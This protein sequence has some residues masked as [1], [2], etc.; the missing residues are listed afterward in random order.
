MA[1]QGVSFDSRGTARDVARRA[2]EREKR[3]V[4]LTSVAAA[5]VLT[6]AKLVV[7]LL[8]GSLGI[9]AEAAHSGLDLVAAALTFFA[10]RL[11]GQPP[12]EEHRYGHGKAENLSAFVEAALLL[13]T[14]VWVI[15]EAIERLF[16][17]EVHVEASP[18]A[19]LVMGLSI[20]VDVGRSRALGRVAREHDSQALAA[21]ALHFRTDIWSSAVV[22]VG[23]GLIKVG[24]WTGWDAGGWL[25]RADALAALGVAAI[26]LGVGGRMLRETADVLL[27]RAPAERAD[28]LVATVADVPGVLETRQLRLRRSGSRAFVDL[29]VAVARTA[30]FGEAHAIS[31]RV[32]EAV[33]AATPRGDVDVVVHMEPVAAPDESPGD[34]VRVLARQN[35]LRAHAVRLRDVDDRLDADLHVEVDPRLTLSAAHVLTARLERAVR[36]ANPQFGRIETHLEAPE[37]VPEWQSDVTTQRA[38][39][40]ARV[41]N[42]AD[43]VAG[44][45][46]CHEVRI[47]RLPADERAFELVLHCWFPGDLAVARV[48]EQ[49]AEIERRLRHALPDLREVL[50]HAEPEERAAGGGRMVE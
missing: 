44:Q 15:Y 6:V 7:G 38:E 31:E 2:A 48:H 49:S 14:A 37:T 32:E 27:D 16:V 47:Y 33:R 50:L 24:E 8:T 22:L 12:D 40:V 43:G 10:V 34:E 9:L 39:T 42:L 29:T 41:R 4:A 26:V 35:G 45:G 23:L 11:A 19:F 20:V 18:W 25:G 30:T 36:A 3:G 1:G 28:A 46:S 13:V 17:A 21:D 5:A